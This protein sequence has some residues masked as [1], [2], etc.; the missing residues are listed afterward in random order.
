M[1]TKTMRS[2]SKSLFTLLLCG[3]CLS[4]G[5]AFAAKKP[6]IIMIFGDDIGQDNISAYHRGMLDY[7]T[8]NIDRIAAEGAL[9]TDHY[10][11]QSCT[12]G[13]ASFA[14]GQNPFRTGLLTI[15]MPGVDHGVRI[16]D[17]TIGVL[18]K[19]YGYQTGQ[20]G[21]NH[22]GDLNKY[23][24]TVRGFDRFYGNLY[25]LNA[26]QEP[27][28][29]DYPAKFEGKSFRD[30][31]GPR[32]VLDCVAS[33]KDDKTVEARWG[34]VGKQVCKDTGPLTIERM[35]TI[36]KKEITPQ[37]LKWME[38]AV[39]RNKASDE[40]EPFFMWFNSTRGHVWVHLS[41]EQYK[42][43]GKGV[44]PDAMDEL[45]WETGQLLDKLDELGIADN[46]I[47]MFSSDNGTEVFTGPDMGGMHPF[48]GEK[49][50][51]TEGGFRVPM[52]IRW[53]EKVKGGTIF[54]G[55]TSH[56]DWMPTLLAAANGGKDS[57]IQA[58]LKKGNFK[59]DGKTFK[60]HLDGYNLLPY[61]TGQTEESP[62]KE[63]YYF[64]AGGDLN[65]VRW[66][67]WKIT[68][69]EMSGALPT[70]WKKTPSWPIITNLRLD[71]YE[72]W[73]DQSQMYLYWFGKHMYLIG[74]AQTLVGKQLKS[75]EDFPPARGSSLSLGKLFDH[76]NYAAPMQ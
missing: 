16:E 5:S 36:E 42:K 52:L 67:K 7:D 40:D 39:A 55:I 21:K 46:T 15:G 17:P 54:N 47:V 6:N 33:T 62:R 4:A 38:E 45:D 41:D 8:P 35:K 27:E 3:L 31:F 66:H 60:A 32:G 29:Y 43:T 70:A 44:F 1:R 25:H 20:F 63:I 48:R 75:L 26:E 56:I 30:Q 74:P 58:A 57:G 61:L 22:L 19:N 11:Q 71:P 2:R 23:L 13:R 28:D 69:T 10:A 68:F 18:L 72:K 64:D 50:L 65:A 14:L 53:P 24:P 9:F 49:G 34:K 51:T 12:A 37:A 59:A 76:I 73:Q